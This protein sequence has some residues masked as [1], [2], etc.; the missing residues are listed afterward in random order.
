M[1][2]TTQPRQIRIPTGAWTAY[3]AICKRLGTTRAEDINAHIRAVIEQHGTA[4]ERAQLAD[5]DAELAERRA[6]K[7]GRPPRTD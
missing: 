2:D 4:E 5:A 3:D 6:R 7:G 1:T